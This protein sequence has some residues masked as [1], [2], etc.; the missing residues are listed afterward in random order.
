MRF[1][2]LWLIIHGTSNVS[3][4]FSVCRLR[5]T[6]FIRFYTYN[7]LS[8]REWLQK[9]I[10]SQLL[11]NAS[12]GMVASVVSDTIVNVF[13]VIKTTKQALGS[14]RDLSYGDTIRMVLAADGWR[15]LFGRGLRTRIIANALQSVVFT[16]IWRGL[17]ER[18]GNTRSDSSG[19]SEEETEP[20]N[21]QPRGEQ[22]R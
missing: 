9:A 18:W 20:R 15:G 11:K 13:R 1:H 7:F 12:V 3:K 22:Q 14:K 8:G 4:Y 21:H 10:P 17:A 6:W 2:R 19:A 16:I 5:S